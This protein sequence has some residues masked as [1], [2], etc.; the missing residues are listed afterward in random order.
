MLNAGIDLRSDTVTVPTEEMR[1]AMRHA[2]VGDDGRGHRGRDSSRGHLFTADEVCQAL[3]RR[4]VLALPQD[5]RVVRFV[6]HYY[7]TEDD[8]LCASRSIR[9]TAAVLRRL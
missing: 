1:E 9:E 2:E 6:T 3:A 7:V 5:K 8:V 4:G